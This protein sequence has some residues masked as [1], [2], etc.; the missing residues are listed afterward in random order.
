MLSI[1]FFLFSCSQKQDEKVNQNKSNSWKIV[2]NQTWKVEENK[3]KLIWEKEAEECLEKSPIK[4]LD[5]KYIRTIYWAFKN[6]NDNLCYYLWFFNN[7]FFL[8][9]ENLQKN[10]KNNLEKDLKSWY[11]EKG[12]NETNENFLEWI[13]S[14]FTEYKYNLLYW[15]YIDY[16]NE[17]VYKKYKF[18]ESP[19]LANFDEKNILDLYLEKFKELNIVLP[20]KYETLKNNFSNKEVLK[21]LEYRSEE[22][23]KPG[24]DYIPV[25]KYFYDLDFENLYNILREKQQKN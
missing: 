22:T 10:I 15:E 5:I 4:N 2:E 17:K 23:K 6:K 18:Q 19:I 9:D 21:W 11:F 7:Q 24:K 12:D 3:E 25:K 16:L 14:Y 20:E 13:F 1:L 8:I